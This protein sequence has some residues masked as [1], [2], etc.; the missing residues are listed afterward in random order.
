MNVDLTGYL[1]LLVPGT[2]VLAI[3]AHNA[4]ISGSSDCMASPVL[5]AVIQPAGG[6]EDPRARLLINELL[7]NSDAAPGA[8]WIELYNCTTPV[9]SRSSWTTC[10]SATTEPTC[11]NISCP[12]AS[13]WRRASSG[14][15]M[16][17]TLRRDFLSPWISRAKP[18]TSR[19]PRAAPS[20]SRVLD[21]VRY[22]VM[23]PDVPYGRFPDGS[24]FL[25]CLSLATAGAANAQP[26]VGDV[27]INEI[28]YHHATRDDSCPPG[29]I[30][31]WLRT[32]ASSRPSTTT[33]S[34]DQTWS[35]PTTG[36]WTITASASVYPAPSSRP[37][38][39]PARSKPIWSRRTK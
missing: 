30:W 35:G 20:R 31:W 36:A 25:D 24:D 22:G 1:N 2:N 3:Q 28:M 5:G 10:I 26:L 18:S 6:G 8:D 38:P 32:P 11:S 37:T 29:P 12:T 4:R 9:P 23:E 16:K 21:A 33:S 7:A 34:S 13:C 17:A 27:V 15:R 39:T 19:P 14:R